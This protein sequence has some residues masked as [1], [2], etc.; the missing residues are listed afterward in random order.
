MVNALHVGEGGEGE[1]SGEK[2]GERW[3]GE[4]GGGRERMHS[5]MIS[6]EE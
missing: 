2:G 1:G 6:E 4:V 3:G 5:V